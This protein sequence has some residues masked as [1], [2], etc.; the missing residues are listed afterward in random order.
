MHTHAFSHTPGHT[1]EE[2]VQHLPLRSI[3]TPTQVQE[4][5]QSRRDHV[6][7][8][9]GTAAT[10]ATVSA[11]FGLSERGFSMRGGKMKSK[12]TKGSRPFNQA[13]FFK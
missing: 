11:I 8:S 10:A 2:L 5:K 4:D 7:Q 3:T 9:E 1:R 12:L 13:H 6:T